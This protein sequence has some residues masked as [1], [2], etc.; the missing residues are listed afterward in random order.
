MR[1]YLSVVLRVVLDTSVLTSALRSR[2]GASFILLR[3]VRRGRLTPLATPSLFLE[4]E[5]ALKRPE[6]REV[7]GL[8]RAD[9]ARVRAGRAVATEPVAVH[10]RWRPHLKDPDDELALELVLNGRA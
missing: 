7:P 9:V 6:Q 10:M 3:A 5:E 4:Y 2:A 1:C 8:S